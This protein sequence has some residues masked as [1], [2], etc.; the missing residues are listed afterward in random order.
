MVQINTRI[1]EELKARL[2]KRAEQNKR[3]LSGELYAILDD[4]LRVPAVPKYPIAPP[5]PV[6]PPSVPDPEPLLP[7]G[8]ND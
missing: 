7:V 1:P 8:W 2:K 3:T 6:Y 4:L 5:I